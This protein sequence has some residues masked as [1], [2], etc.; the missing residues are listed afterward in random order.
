MTSAEVCNRIFEY[1]HIP[2]IA[3]GSEPNTILVFHY[4]GSRHFAKI[5]FV[6]GVINIDGPHGREIVVTTLEAAAYY[7]IGCSEFL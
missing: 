2:L 3:K 5:H 1:H 7:I 6:D 4:H